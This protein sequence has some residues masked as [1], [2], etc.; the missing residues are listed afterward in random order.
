MSCPP[1]EWEFVS[2]TVDGKGVI[3]ARYMG[4]GAK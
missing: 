3:F 4:N 1:G 2:R